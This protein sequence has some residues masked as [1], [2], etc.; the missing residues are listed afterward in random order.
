MG[1]SPTPK[2]YSILNCPGAKEDIRLLTGSSSKVNVSCVSFSVLAIVYSCGNIGA[3][4]CM[5]MACANMGS[6]VCSSVLIAVYIE[7]PQPGGL[8]PL[9]DYVGE[10]LDEF[11]AQVMV[12]IAFSAEA[13]GIKSY[14]PGQVEGAPV[15]MPPVGREEPRPAEHVP[16]VEG[17]NGNWPAPRHEH[18][19]SHFAAGDQ[20]KLV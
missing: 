5:L 1:T 13:P 3:W 14:G 11:V 17:F 8:E 16:F 9:H 18:F 4:F 15:E 6:S 2:T 20:V 19:D 12:I 10:P 7:E